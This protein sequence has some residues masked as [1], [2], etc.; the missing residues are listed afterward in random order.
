M[1]PSASE[2]REMHQGVGKELREW[3]LRLKGR[4]ISIRLFGIANEELGKKIGE[5]AKKPSFESLAEVHDAAAKFG[6]IFSKY[7]DLSLS[8]S[9]ITKL[10]HKRELARKHNSPASEMAGRIYGILANS[11]QMEK[12]RAAVANADLSNAR[13]LEKDA[14]NLVRLSSRGRLNYDEFMGGAKVIPTNG[15]PVIKPAF[16]HVER[17]GGEGH[18]LY[19]PFLKSGAHAV[20]HTHPQPY[21]S[22]YQTWSKPHDEFSDGRAGLAAALASP[23]AGAEIRGDK[24][25]SDSL[26]VPIIVARTYVGRGA[27]VEKHAGGN[28]S[29]FGIKKHLLPVIQIY[30]NGETHN[31]T[32][33]PDKNKARK[34]A[35]AA[36]K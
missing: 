5:Y 19:S 36:G 32:I 17:L 28:N 15:G 20:L 18:F 24:A 10:M 27:F 25:V 9:R 23:D 22:L 7:L 31:V 29:V 30:F 13:M 35:L 21:G 14:M 3:H 11:P 8:R 34:K 16:Y 1:L 33:I 6:T 26:G 4:P 12:A 2:L